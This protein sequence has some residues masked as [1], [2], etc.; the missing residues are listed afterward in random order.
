MKFV[1]FS[2]LSILAFCNTL[3]A[4]SIKPADAAKHVGESVT[5]CGKIFSAKY[6]DKAAK[7]VTLLNMGAAY[8]DQPITIVIY[9][10]LR[11]KLSVKPEEKWKDKNICVTG[12]IELFKEK[13]QIVVEKEEQV[14]EQ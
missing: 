2:L 9:E 7:K 13:P 8:P 4:Q 10:E 3:S 6:F 14:Q 11:S 5:V 12:K 1:V